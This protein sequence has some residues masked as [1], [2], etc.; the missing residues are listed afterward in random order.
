MLKNEKSAIQKQ[1]LVTNFLEGDGVKG[2]FNAGGVNY[3][4][5]GRIASNRS[6][7]GLGGLLSDRMASTRRAMG[8]N[9]EKYAN[10]GH[11]ALGGTG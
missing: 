11:N 2:G 9:Q 1:V 6:R 8:R 7:R 5:P 3:M 4:F 10:M